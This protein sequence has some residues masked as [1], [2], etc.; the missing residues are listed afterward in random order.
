MIRKEVKE[1][2]FEEFLAYLKTKKIDLSKFEKEEGIPISI[3]N[4]KLST[5]ESI[6]RFLRE[7]KELR[8]KE[9]AKILKKNSGHIGVIYRNAVKKYSKSFT[10]Y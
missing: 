5:L 4:S 6:V 2:L 9:I 10:G 1:A 7:K 3:F 8:Y